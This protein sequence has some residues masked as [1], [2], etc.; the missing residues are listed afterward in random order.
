[1]LSFKDSYEMCSDGSLEEILPLEKVKPD[2]SF[3]SV[4]YAVPVY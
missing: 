3:D 4:L 1:M 2:N